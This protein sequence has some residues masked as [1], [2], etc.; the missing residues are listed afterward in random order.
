[1]E[2]ILKPLQAQV[3]VIWPGRTKHKIWL[4]LDN[5]RVHNSQYSQ[6][7]IKELGFKRAPHPP[8]SPDI[9]PSDFFLFGYVKEQL[10][11]KSFRDG[12]KLFQMISKII[13]SVSEKTRKKVFEE[14][15]DRYEWVTTHERFYYP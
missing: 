9:A 1:M 4:H 11:G 15:R 7:E 2:N 13:N 14:W 5:C 3:N 10:K 6:T 12:D 8:Y